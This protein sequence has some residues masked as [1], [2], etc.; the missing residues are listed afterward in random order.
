MNGAAKTKEVSH[1]RKK[2]G[3]CL[4]DAG[5]IDNKI[6]EKALEIQKTEKK[7]IGQILIDMGVTDDIE[8]AKALSRQLNIPFLTV[9]E[10]NPSEDIKSLVPPEMVENYLMIPIKKENKKLLVVMANP[11]DFYAVDD[12]RFVTQMTIE[13]AVAP[14]KDI[15]D[16]IEKLYPKYDL[17]KEF[18]GEPEANENVELVKRVDKEEKDVAQLLKLTELPPVVR[19]TNAILADAIKLKASDLHIEPQKTAVLVRYRVDGVV[20]EIMKTDKHVH[21]SLVSRIKIISNMDIAIR[22]K[23]Q[24]GKAQIKYKNKSYDLRVST[25]PTSYGEK[26]T[27]RILDPDAAMVRIEG[28]GFSDTSIRDFT[29]VV[30]RPQGIILVTGPTGSGKSSTLYACLNKL[31]T[32]AVNIITVEDPIEYDVEGINQV[33]INPKAGITFASGLRSILRQ[34]PDI[35][36]VGEIRDS[37]TASIAFQAAQ[38]G[39]LVFS[40]LHTNDSSSAVTRLVDL[41]VEPFLISASLNAVIGQRLV[42]KVCQPCRAPEALPPDFIHRLPFHLEKKQGAEFW[43]G[44][45]CSMCNYSGYSGRMALLELLLITPALREILVANG[46]STAIKSAA[47]KEGFHSM[48]MDGISKALKGLTTIEEVFRVAPPEIGE[49]SQESIVEPISTEEGTKEE[50][51]PESSIPSL[52]TVRPHKI[53]LADDSEIVTKIIRNILEAENYLV[54]TAKNGLEA[55]KL[56]MTEKPDLVVTD[57]L[58][59]EMDG[60][61]L[62]KKLK[63]Q[64]E[65]RYMPVIML[66]GKDELDYEV[67]GLNAG[68]D[69][70]LAK[71]VNA[72]R[73]L[74]RINRLLNKSN[75]G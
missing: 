12:L 53:L 74:A 61:T 54:I 39:H 28:L 75:A 37:E 47:S 21:A 68:A 66:S 18:S 55:L 73:L 59:P 42:R 71:P 29:D 25:L 69:D 70:Y 6:L 22:R 2:L 52:T 16:A 19:F 45:G 49:I 30:S 4:I 50:D 14:Q 40:T 3:E 67:D 72:K 46:S 65:T 44:A 1:G 20:R 33:Q 60:L 43:K 58:M 23:P 64:F 10:I 5:L 41:G 17:E 38:T 11:M 57:F 24:D 32:P 35:V 36:L 7:K 31:N 34:D 26:V 51:M 15:V 27:I 48:S 56:A 8:I 62:V 13:M 9:E 63:S